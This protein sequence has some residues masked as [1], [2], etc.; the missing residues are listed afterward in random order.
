MTQLGLIGVLPSAGPLNL[1][2]PMSLEFRMLNN[3]SVGGQVAPQLS[4]WISWTHHDVVLVRQ[5][6]SSNSTLSRGSADPIFDGQQEHKL[7]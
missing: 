2:F 4:L 7:S 5:V 1:M 3:P 6:G